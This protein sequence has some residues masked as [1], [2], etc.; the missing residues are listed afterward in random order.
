MSIATEQESKGSGRRGVDKA[1]PA[2]DPA[3]P[4]ESITPP[5]RLR[6]RPALV[7]AS[8]AAIC[9]GALLA[10]WAYAGASTSQDVLAVRATVHRGELI[11]RA[12]LMTAQIS[13]D[14]V[15]KPLPASAADAVVGKRAAMD[16][17]AGGLV[18]QEDITSALVPA[19]GMSV[20]G[21][22]LP[23][24]LMPGT[25][26]Q[27]GDQVRIVATPCAPGVATIRTWS[28]DCS[29]VPGIS[30]GGRLTPTTDMPLA[31]TNAEVMSSW[32]TRPP[33]ARSIAARFPTTASAAEAGNGLRTGSTLICAVIRSARVIS[34]P[35][36]TVAR[37]ART[38]WEVLAPA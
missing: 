23:P 33:A 35:R 17:A 14:P 13:V 3:V 21:V 12:D 32:V 10:V 20:V 7:A 19:K 11:T 15:L 5:P 38:S 25:Q 24:A 26:L 28:P 34:S 30:A 22:S 2:S 37:T 27:S 16:L 1:P 4:G 18:T 36:W 8:V 6:R 9:L 31:G 29:W